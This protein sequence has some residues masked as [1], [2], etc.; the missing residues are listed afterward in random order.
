MFG[1]SDDHNRRA[2]SKS[3]RIRLSGRITE[4]SVDL[5]DARPGSDVAAFVKAV[6][7]PPVRFMLSQ[8]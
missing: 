1:I 3:D 2:I 7:E 8:S 4:S 5:R 6:V